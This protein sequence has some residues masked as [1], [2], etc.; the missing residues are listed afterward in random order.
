MYK[1]TDSSASGSWFIV[2][3]MRGFDRSGIN[4]LTANT[5][6]AETPTGA[7]TFPNAIG[8]NF[9]GAFNGTYIYI[10]IRRGPMKVPTT[11]TQV[12]NPTKSNA[13][14]GTAI[15]TNFVVDSQWINYLSGTPTNTA[16]NDRLRGVSTTATESGRYLVSSSTAAEATTLSYTNK[17]GNTGYL[18]PSATAYD[19]AAY[20]SF[21][22]APSFFDEVC[23]NGDASGNLSFTHNLG[24]TPE[25]VIMKARASVGYLWYVYCA[26]APQPLRSY[27]ALSDTYA[28]SD[29]G[30]T[31]YAPTSTTFQ[32]FQGGW[33]P[34]NGT[35]VVYLFAT[36]PGV[37]KV[38]GYTG[39]GTTQTINCGF[40]GGARWV[41]V[42]RTDSTGD[43]YVWDTARGMV[44][45]TDPSL[46]LNST[47]AEVN[48]NSVYTIATGFQIVSTAAGIN[49]S[50]GSYIFLAIA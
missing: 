41:M 21:S 10:A 42:K 14:N 27:S 45:G 33:V 12:F 23:T 36:C 32:T 37:S 28:F 19:N 1:R 39:T 49:A 15:T 7:K 4:F 17:W 24:A 18:I 47:A 11:G 13:A 44:S 40:V 29:S 22:R 46:L 50:G 5:S 25:L 35:A 3:I 2:D 8:F 38:G 30:L 34:N 43:W 26:N 48:A 31:Y 16:F 6:N 20:Y 9:E